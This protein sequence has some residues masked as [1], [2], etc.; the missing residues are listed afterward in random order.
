MAAKCSGV[1]ARQVG[2]INVTGGGGGAASNP[3]SAD[4]SAI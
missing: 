3:F 4:R 2:C 1:N